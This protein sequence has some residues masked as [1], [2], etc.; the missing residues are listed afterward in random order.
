MS[1]QVICKFHK[2]P[3][4][5]KQA[6]L[7]PRLN[8]VCFG[9]KGQ[10]I[11]NWPELELVRDFMPVQVNFKIHKNPIKT[12]LADKVKYGM[13]AARKEEIYPKVNSPIISMCAAFCSG[14]GLRSRIS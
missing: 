5:T 8:I 2:D 11:P 13:F 7:Q 9:A 14:T 3:I 10:W 12:K 1:V 4:K 6:L